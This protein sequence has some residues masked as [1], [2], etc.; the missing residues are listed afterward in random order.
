MGG[1]V[2][3]LLD[4]QRHRGPDDEGTWS[5]VDCTLGHRRLSI[6]DLSRAGRQP[7]A[8]EDGN[9]WITFNGEIYNFQAL[10]HELEGCG[11]RFRTLT[12]TETIVHAYEQWG[13]GCLGRLRG[14]FAFGIWDQPRR[15]LFLARDRVG[16]KPLFYTH[17]DGRLIFASELQGLLADPAVP[18]EVDV[19][20]IDDYLSWGY[21]PAPR[22]GFRNISKLPPGHWLTVDLGRPGA[23]TAVESYW[24]LEYMPKLATTEEEA[25]EALRA[26]LTEAVRLR[27]TADVPLGAFLSGGVDSSI[28]VGLMAQLSSQ[29]VKTFSIGFE[30][31]A[32]NE[33][34]HARRIAERWGT[35]HHEFVVRADALE[36]LPTL[37]RHYGEPFAD[38]SAIPTFYVCRATSQ[39]VT[40]A[41]NGDGGDESFGGYERHRANHVAEQLGRIPGSRHAASALA[42][43]L[44]DSANRRSLTRRARRFLA[45]AHQ[46]M[47]S[48]YRRWVGYFGGQDKDLLYT[49]KFRA[50][51]GEEEPDSWMEALCRQTAGMPAADAAMSVD[52]QSYLP[53][54]LL[55]KVDI[56]SMAN[57]LEARSP[58]LDHQLME[59]VARLPVDLKVRGSDAKYLLKRSFA[60]LLPPENV[61]RPK[62]GF[63]VPVGDWFRGPLRDLLVDS[64]LSSTSTARGYFR[65]EALRCLVDEHLERRNDHTA[66]LWNLVM[67]EAWHREMIDH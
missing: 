6:I 55:V 25:A 21:V 22:T 51:L 39:E 4:A 40:V 26:Q 48:R 17:I 14:M 44:P 9:V 16:K 38:S 66:Q 10:R 28:T 45:V 49:D 19:E 52:V 29:P 11:H 53:Y 47:A 27:M 42:R 34:H 23:P 20:A 63:G 2:S 59:F 33:L 41:L 36:V 64:L 18:R 57:S 1:S 8:N 43:A 3:P 54:D 5:D 60:D 12:D 37:V 7:L 56:T 15:R 24:S 32:F 30:E 58:F 62:M 65:P 67:L 35:D 46:P 50:V 31:A 13:I 61:R